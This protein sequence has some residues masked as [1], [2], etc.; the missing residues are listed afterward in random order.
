MGR[1][2]F[3]PLVLAFLVSCF[4]NRAAPGQQA[5]DSVP[6]AAALTIAS[7]V[8][9]R[10][11]T[12]ALIPE[13]YQIVLADGSSKT[14]SATQ[15][16]GLLAEAAGAVA[17]GATPALAL[18]SE[19]FGTPIATAGVTQGNSILLPT[20]ALIAECQPLVSF[21]VR[22]GGYPSAV[23]VSG[24]R[25]SAAEFMVALASALQYANETGRLPDNVR[26]VTAKPPA[27]WQIA[28]QAQRPEPQIPA[29]PGPAPTPAQSTEVIPP[30]INLVPG[31]GARLSGAVDMVVGLT[32]PPPNATVTFMLDGRIKS[33]SNWPPFA[34]HLNVD[35]L[36]PGKHT[37]TVRVEGTEGGL[38]ATKDF[39]FV[40]VEPAPAKTTPESPV[41]TAP[42]K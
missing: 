23:W 40:A 4:V 26:V 19:R 42:A 31:N 11:A 9:E 25:L 38:L 29:I 32:P 35:E 28:P 17:A 24:R 39:T 12:Q 8:S 18:P 41:K 27:A 36:N 1:L 7:Q 13:S 10:V 37:V 6:F 22:L 34:L 30:K 2:R 3:S 5:T 21:T 14:I 33:A 20:N 16:L 15:A